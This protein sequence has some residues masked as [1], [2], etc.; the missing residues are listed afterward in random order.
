MRIL[1]VL[2][3]CFLVIVVV[4]FS[5]KN[6][7]YVRV[8]YFTVVD[9]FEV[10]LFLVILLGLL[11]G[12]FTGTMVDLARGYRLKR[13][14]R[15]QQRIMD[16]LKKELKTLRHSVLTGKRDRGSKEV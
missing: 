11:L 14:I 1:K 3:F 10:P 4:A 8:G 7:G 6:P 13:A 9:P 16:N 15:R 12:V 2:L 5:I